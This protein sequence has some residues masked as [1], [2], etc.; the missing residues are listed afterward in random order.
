M[1]TAWFLK[2][3]SNSVEVMTGSS[4]PKWLK[5]S[6]P[7]VTGR[8]LPWAN[9]ALI[10]SGSREMAVSKPSSMRYK[11]ASLMAASLGQEVHSSPS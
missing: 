5:E 10:T 11:G 3:G 7:T 2:T 8:T 9:H 1:V 4:G 6:I